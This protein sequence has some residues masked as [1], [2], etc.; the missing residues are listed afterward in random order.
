M[1]A[2]RDTLFP[3]RKR[4]PFPKRHSDPIY[5]MLA[6]MQPS[7]G[8]FGRENGFECYRDDRLKV[9]DSPQVPFELSGAAALTRGDE[10]DQCRCVKPSRNQPC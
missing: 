2:E 3:D 5:N 1:N 4:L 6:G 9:S 10:Y 8:Y 7:H